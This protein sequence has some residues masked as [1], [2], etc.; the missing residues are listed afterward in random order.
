MDEDD[1]ARRA[2]ELASLVGGEGGYIAWGGGPRPVS[3]IVELVEDGPAMGAGQRGERALLGTRVLQIDPEGEDGAV[4]VR[5]RLDVLMPAHGV[6]A[7]GPLEVELRAVEADVRP[8]EIGAEIDH[9]G[10]RR[11]LPELGML[12]HRL[13]QAADVRLLRGVIGGEVELIVGGSEGARFL[14]L[15]CYHGTEA[16]EPGRAHVAGHGEEALLEVALALPLLE[17]EGRGG[18]D[19]FGRHGY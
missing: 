4:G 16:R 12:V 19:L 3:I 13:A 2:A 5:P 9:G 18:Q 14:D 15:G 17:H 11:E 1:G 10:I 8:E 6:S 7:F